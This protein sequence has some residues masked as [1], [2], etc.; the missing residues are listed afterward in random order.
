M[1]KQEMLMPM[2]QSRRSSLSSDDALSQATSYRSIKLRTEQV[3]HGGVS[4]SGQIADRRYSINRRDGVWWSFL[5]GN[6]RPRRR[7]SRRQVDK[8][9]FLFDWQEPRILYLAI[10][11]LLLS[12]VD[13]LF[14]LNLLEL[15]ATEAN[16]V[17][18]SV[19]EQSVE[20]FL[21]V[22]LSLTALSLMILVAT[23]R[24]QFFRALNVE[25]L[26]QAFFGGYL[27]LICYEAYMFVYVFEF[28]FF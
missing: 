3:F 23:A 21:A 16:F 13:A 22:K 10:G 24:R 4:T 20:R 11:L 6:F 1:Q 7:G 27:L 17:M 5:Y 14:T 15:G 8:H 26:L 28:K 25:H 12:C 2:G 19:L 9:D 18:A